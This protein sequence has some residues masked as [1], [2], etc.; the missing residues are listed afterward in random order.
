MCVY[1]PWCKAR[2]WKN[3]QNCTSKQ[4]Q[5]SKATPDCAWTVARQSVG[6]IFARAAKAD[7]KQFGINWSLHSTAEHMAGIAA[8]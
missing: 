4:K 5:R 3:Y 8:K 1:V 6:E 7:K 2:K